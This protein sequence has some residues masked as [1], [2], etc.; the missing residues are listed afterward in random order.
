MS[1]VVICEFMDPA[2]VDELSSRFAVRYD[3]ALVDRPEALRAAVRECRALVVR[4]RAQVRGELLAACQRLRV[5]GR[6]GVGLDNIDLE[7]CRRRGIAVMP[8]TGANVQAVAEYVIGALHLLLRGAYLATDRV[9]GGHWPRTELLGG[10]IGGKT[11]GLVGFGATAREVARRAGALG[12]QVLAHD[13]QLAES[14]P[15]WRR[16][17]AAR[18]PLPAL[19]G[20]ADAVSLHVPL[21]EQTRHL[22]GAVALARMKPQAVLINTARGGVVDEAALAAA[23]RAGKLAGAMLDVF[24]HEPLPAGSALQGVPNL[25]LTPHI[26]GITRESNARV[27]AVTAA[28]VAR[29]LEDNP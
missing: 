8:A 4:N 16:L 5:V 18:T 17:S 2:A 29:H 10:E 1:D 3:A 19:L 27:G 23:L 6:L 12:M 24:E 26:A 14:D 15:V 22:I 25:V 13:P 20:R 9:L 21:L 28:N 11:L 7:A